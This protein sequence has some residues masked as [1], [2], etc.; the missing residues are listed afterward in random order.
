MLIYIPSLNKGSVYFLFFIKV[1]FYNRRFKDGEKVILNILLAIGTEVDQERGN[2][3]Q[4]SVPAPC[5]VKTDR[6]YANPS[7]LSTRRDVYC[8]V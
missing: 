8:S 2:A 5:C 7:A 1:D 6:R 4:F 3:K